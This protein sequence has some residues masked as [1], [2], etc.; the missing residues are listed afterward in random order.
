L[1]RCCLSRVIARAG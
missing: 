1:R